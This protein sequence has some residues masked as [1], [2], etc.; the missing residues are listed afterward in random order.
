[1]DGKKEPAGR[2]SDK[3]VPVA[4]AVPDIF[5]KGANAVF[6]LDGAVYSIGKFFENKFHPPTLPLP[7]PPKKNPLRVLLPSSQQVDT[8]FLTGRLRL[9]HRANNNGYSTSYFSFYLRVK[10]L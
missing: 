4:S 3:R 10:N 6:R 2:R 7:S 5:G 1:M 9:A 8:K